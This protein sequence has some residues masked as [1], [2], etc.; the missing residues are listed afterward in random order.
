MLKF[1]NE[2]PPM[3]C[4]EFYPVGNWRTIKGFYLG[5]WHDQICDLKD[6]SCGVIGWES[7]TKGMEIS[8][9]TLTIFK[10]EMRPKL[11]KW[12]CD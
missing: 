1:D 4:Q 12:N 2:G 3:P 9:K 6:N 8:W 5:M 7:K 10:Q 11:R